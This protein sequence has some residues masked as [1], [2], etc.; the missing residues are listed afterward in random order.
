MQCV[1]ILIKV[2]VWGWAC[3]DHALKLACYSLIETIG[4]IQLH[5]IR[6]DKY[7]N[8]LRLR[9]VQIYHGVF[10][11]VQAGF[12]EGLRLVTALGGGGQRGKGKKLEENTSLARKHL[13]SSPRSDATT[14][15]F[16]AP[17]LIGT[18]AHRHI[19]STGDPS[20]ARRKYERRRTKEES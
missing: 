18:Q 11:C 17:A 1:K 8:N 12:T 19:P 14:F 15:M 5:A 2:C 7:L 3:V 20:R 13:I 10:V 9:A 16:Q 6:V 4:R